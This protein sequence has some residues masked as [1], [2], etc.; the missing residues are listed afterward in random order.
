MTVSQPFRYRFVIPSVPKF[1]S[2]AEHLSR[3]DKLGIYSNFGPLSRELEDGIIRKF[4]LAQESAVC[5]S[6]ATAG[7]SAALIA[8]GVRGKVLVPAFTFPASLGAVRAANLEPHVVDVDLNTWTLSSDILDRELN[9]DIG[10]V[11]LVAPFGMRRDFSESIEKCI[12]RGIQVVVDNAAGLGVARSHRIVQPNVFE[13]FSLHATKTFAIGEGGV[14]AC[15]ETQSIG[16]RNAINFALYSDRAPT[17]GFNGK[18]SELHS[19]V[20]LAQL[21]EIQSHVKLRINC[22]KSYIQKLA[23]FPMLEMPSEA[24]I[25]PWQC[26]PVLFPSAE[27][28]DNF[29]AEAAKSGLQIRRYY[30]PS[31]SK[32]AGVSHSDCPNA[33]DLSTRMCALPVRSGLAFE[34]FEEIIQITTNCIRACS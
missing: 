5:C 24:D 2:Y 28:A 29:E 25:A 15:H 1:S 20:G 9:D 8:G 16:V 33:E 32:V 7:L 30:T 17:W 21:E 22:A 4:G 19:A 11:M 27:T 31:L 3:A 18:L 6:S 14:V 12:A 13:V 10:A 23:Q 34:E 26:F